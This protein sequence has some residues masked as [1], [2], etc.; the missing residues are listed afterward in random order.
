L[1]QGL[2]YSKEK[3]WNHQI[4]GVLNMEDHHVLVLVIMYFNNFCILNVLSTTSIFK[5]VL[6]VVIARFLNMCEELFA[7][8]FVMPLSF[9]IEDGQC[10]WELERQ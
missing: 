3:H 10:E 9:T 4:L 5:N 6:V 7:S 1:W 2:D 8:C